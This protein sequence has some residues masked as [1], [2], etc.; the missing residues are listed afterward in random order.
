MKITVILG[1]VRPDSKTREAAKVVMKRIKSI[2]GSPQL[3]DPQDFRV[4]H[5][6]GDFSTEI[7]EKMMNMIGGSSGVIICT[8]EYNGTFSS[9]L[10]AIFENLGYPLAIAGKPIS[11]LG[12]ASGKIGAIKALEHLRSVCSHCGAIVLP[13]SLSIAEV[14]K[15]FDEK[16]GELTFQVQ[17]QISQ[18]TDQLFQYLNKYSSS[19]AASQS[20]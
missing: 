3:L 14:D 8:P 20:L 19:T 17:D 15:V 7:R 9:V 1:S 6:G 18:F 11:L 13:T 12:V 2:G 10:M 16:K 5:L 4:S